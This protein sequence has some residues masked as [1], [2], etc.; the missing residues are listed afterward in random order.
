MKSTRRYQLGKAEK[1]FSICS[2]LPCSQMLAP[3]KI[4]RYYNFEVSHGTFNAPCCVMSCLQFG[5]DLLW[6][7]SELCP[8]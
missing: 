8:V 1:Y 6:G 3:I 4:G 2:E 7:C 5:V